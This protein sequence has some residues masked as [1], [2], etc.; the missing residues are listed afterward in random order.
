MR[1]VVPAGAYLAA[2]SKR[3]NRACSNRTGSISTIGRSLARSTSTLMLRQDFAR[4][5]QGTAD[6]LAEIMQRGVRHDGAG[7]QLGHVEQVCDEAVEPLGLVDDRGE[8]IGLG[9]LVQRIRQAP[10]RACR[11]EHCRERRL[12]VVRDRGQ[13]RRAQSIRLS[14]SLCPIQVFDKADALDGER[15]LIHQRIEQPPLIGRQQRPWLVAVD[16]DD[17]DGAAAGV[18]RQEQTLCAGKRIRTAPGR[19]DR[20]PMPTSPRPD[21]PRRAC[22]PE[23]SPPSRQSS[24]SRA[25]ARRPEP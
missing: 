21:P 10:K 19:L 23:D 8:E 22:P 4:P 25:A 1:T 9:M 13:Q 14:R 24:H 6:D 5:P 2:L 3:L 11:P 18:H 17:P 15:R 16:A 7:F 20:S 12:E